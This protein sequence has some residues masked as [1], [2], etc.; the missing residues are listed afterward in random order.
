MIYQFK[1]PACGL[2]KEV[3]RHHSECQ[4]TEYCSCN[5]KMNRIYYTPQIS[6]PSVVT[7]FN[8]ALGVDIKDKRQ[9]RDEI[10]KVND[11][12]GGD[13]VEIGN[14]R[15]NKNLSPRMNDYSFPRGI[16]DDAIKE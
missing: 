5:N 8:P 4:L 11:T 3:V 2:C 16:F 6:I 15:L 9:L 12:T 7:G 10:K 14:E 13:L 1:C